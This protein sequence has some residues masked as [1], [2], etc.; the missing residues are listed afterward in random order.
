MSSKGVK[1]FEAVMRPLQR[2]PLGFHYFCGGF[3]AW[4]ARDVVRYRRDVIVQNLSRSFPDKSY[5]AIAALTDEFYQH[6]GEL[7]GEALWFGGCRGDHRRLQKQNLC[8][9]KNPEV[10]FEAY[11]NSPSVML[12]G[13][14]F[15]NWELFG[16]LLDF[17]REGE[18]KEFSQDNICVVYKRQKSGFWDEFMAD[19]RTCM[20]GRR[21]DGLL[22]S[23]KV[24]RYALLHRNERKVYCFY[25][26]Q[27]PYKSASRHEV[28]DFMHQKTQSMAGGMILAHKMGMSAV[29]LSIDRVRKGH[30]AIGFREICRDASQMSPEEMTNTYYKFLQEDI[31]AN[32]MNY[33]WSHERW[34]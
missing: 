28:P 30:Y 18:N 3:L 10:L 9:V 33:L 23:S 24:L 14:H 31:E 15:G 25:T 6:F 17:F 11:R 32:P 21:Y 13:S 26:D 4:I 29:Y 34:K 5:K 1:I 12:L 8:E 20:L 16:G 2:L 22:E 27:Y 7:F 19:N